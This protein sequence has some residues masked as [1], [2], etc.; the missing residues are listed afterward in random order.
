MEPN[1][2]IEASFS[3]LVIS[4]G[5]TAVMSLGLAPNPH[6]GKTE[7]DMS[8]AKFNIDLLLTL[9]EKTKGN[10]VDDEAKLLDHV[11]NDLQMKFVSEKK[12]EN[13]IKN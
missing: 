3:T 1:Q 13:T 12:A 9:Q 10:L 5:S 4:I 11:I 2:N 7:K 6:T 8:V